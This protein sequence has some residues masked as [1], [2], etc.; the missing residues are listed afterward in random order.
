VI[1]LTVN[2]F[3]FSHT[4]K[5]A[6]SRMALMMLLG[7]IPFFSS[8]L[9]S[10]KQ[11]ERLLKWSAVFSGAT[12]LSTLYQLFVQGMRFTNT[13]ATAVQIERVT[14]TTDFNA[15]WVA[16]I[17]AAGMIILWCLVLTNPKPFIF[18][19]ASIFSLLAVVTM[20]ST[21][22]RGPLLAVGLVLG[23]LLTTLNLRYKF[24]LLLFVGLLCLILFGS[25][26]GSF[27]L[28]GTQRILTSINIALNS[29]IATFDELDFLSAGRFSL[30]R[31]AITL[32]QENPWTGVGIGNFPGLYA[33]NLVLELLSEYGL[34]GFVLFCGFL[35]GVGQAGY[36]IYQ[37]NRNDF[38]T[39]SA[40]GVLILSLGQLMFS[41]NIQNSVM[42]WIASAL[43]LN[44][45]VT[46]T[47]QPAAR[48]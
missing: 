19:F 4:N 33:H 47:Q 37:N 14:S 6:Q 35:L 46:Q 22:S 25:S 48:A 39:L 21:G 31:L 9:L 2:W 28:R 23:F 34:V 20:I 45:G 3:L 5:Y 26:M 10:K 15:L 29:S 40:L 7:I 18:I 17:I 42:F 38:V 13:R 24:S 41:G 11:L 1:W 36:S 8:L 43:V 12:M 16:Y 30:W 27:D 32:W 44:L